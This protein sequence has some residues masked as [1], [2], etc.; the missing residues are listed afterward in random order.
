MYA[1]SILAMVTKHALKKEACPVSVIV[2]LKISELVVSLWSY[3]N[4]YF[5][6]CCFFIFAVDVSKLTCPSTEGN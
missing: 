2:K 6:Y 1:P 4:Y 3:K 5:Y